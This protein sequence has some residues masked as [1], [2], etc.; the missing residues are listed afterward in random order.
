MR[1]VVHEQ[2]RVAVVR[3]EGR[4][5]LG[6]GVDDLRRLVRE[7]ARRRSGLV[8]DL[9]RIGEIDTSGLAALL[10][11]R[12]LLAENGCPL[13][14]ARLPKRIARLTRLT[15]LDRL[16][17]IYPGAVEALISFQPRPVLA[18]ESAA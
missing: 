7:A 13:K 9:E 8:L 11:C 3:L 10:E 5:A 12:A 17:E 16:F 2:D 1:A 15:R 4:L 6:D 14:L 18:F